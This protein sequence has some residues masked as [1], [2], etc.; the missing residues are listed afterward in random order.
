MSLCSATS[1]D[2]QRMLQCDCTE[3]G[4]LQEL[5]TIAFRLQ[6]WRNFMFHVVNVA[7][8]DGGYLNLKPARGSV[9]GELKP[10]FTRMRAGQR[11]ISKLI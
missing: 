1:P 11:E 6:I 4:V 9:E 10:L 8:I 5:P 3:A 2:I 7:V